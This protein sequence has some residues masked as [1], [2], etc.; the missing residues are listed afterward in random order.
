MHLLFLQWKVELL[1]TNSPEYKASYTEGDADASF[2]TP[3]SKVAN[4]SAHFA[5]NSPEG[6]PEPFC[7]DTECLKLC[8]RELAG[9]VP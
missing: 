5:L 9:A 6:T 7:Y 4:R 3:C 8:V 1:A 2:V